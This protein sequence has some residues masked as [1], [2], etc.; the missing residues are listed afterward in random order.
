MQW[1]YDE[2]LALKDYGLIM[3][4]RDAV[5]DE[6]RNSSSEDDLEKIAEI[7]F[8]LITAS[9]FDM[10]M[11]NGGLC[12][13]LVNE[14]R[15][16]GA[17]LDKALLAF[18][19]EQHKRITEEFCMKNGIDLSNLEELLPETTDPDQVMENYMQLIRKY[20]FANFD[21][22]YFAID[23]EYPLE[24]ILGAYI[25]ENMALFFGS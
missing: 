20:P 16:H 12:Q 14:G 7:R 5:I 10:E 2:L 13:F 23:G 21:K 17:M 6:I 19:A 22:A 25:R 3:E 8:Y 9:V 1:N 15:F 4:A 11:Q 24:G 18:G